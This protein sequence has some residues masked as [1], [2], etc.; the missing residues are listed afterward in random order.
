MSLCECYPRAVENF[1]KYNTNTITA[2]HCKLTA[3]WSSCIQRCQLPY[4]ESTCIH[5]A[6]WCHPSI[7]I[8]TKLLHQKRI[9][10]GGELCGGVALISPIGSVWAISLC[11]HT[12]NQLWGCI[13]I[14]P[15][16]IR[17][18]IDAISRGWTSGT[19]FGVKCLKVNCFS[20]CD[21]E[22]VLNFLLGAFWA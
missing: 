22:E 13:V 12:E 11:V 15:I 16:W 20:S 18:S 3:S 1:V 14:T 6:G 21:S 10:K 2:P 7:C 5:L 19:I 8:R 17:Q 4:K 9:N